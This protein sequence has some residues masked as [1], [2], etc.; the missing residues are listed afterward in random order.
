[1]KKFNAQPCCSVLLLIGVGI[2][3]PTTFAPAV[4]AQEVKPAD[5]NADDLQKQIQ[6]LNQSL[7][8]GD[9]AAALKLLDPLIESGPTENRGEW[10]T[11][12]LDILLAEDKS[13]GLAANRRSLGWTDPSTDI[14]RRSTW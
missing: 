6:Q 10:I 8:A 7:Q 9:N 3:A 13:Q 14:A 12:K 4:F 11:S 5:A 1:M 2:A